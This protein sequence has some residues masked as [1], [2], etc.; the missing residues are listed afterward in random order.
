VEADLAPPLGANG[1]TDG[2]VGL[3]AREQI[4]SKLGVRHSW[5]QILEAVFPLSSPPPFW[6]PDPLQGSHIRSVWVCGCQQ[7]SWLALTPSPDPLPLLRV[8]GKARTMAPLRQVLSSV[9]FQKDAQF[10]PLP[11]P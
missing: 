4:L 7:F 8:L 9:C 1:K 3:A 11:L 5:A 2:A 6:N 10:L